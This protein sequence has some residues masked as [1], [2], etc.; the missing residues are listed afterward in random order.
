[1]PRLKFKG[2]T[3]R[4]GGFENKMLI[5]ATVKVIQK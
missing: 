5:G 1:M 3:F 4:D 2:G